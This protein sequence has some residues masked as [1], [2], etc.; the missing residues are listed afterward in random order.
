LM[1][2]SP[3]ALAGFASFL[4]GFGMGLL[5]FTCI[6]LIQDSVDWSLRG[7]ATASNIFARSLGSTLGATVLGAVLNAGIDRLASG[8]TAVRIH[9]VLDQPSGLALVAA[10]PSAQAVLAQALHLTFFGVLALALLAFA[11]SWFI[12]VPARRLGPAAVGT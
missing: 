12:P 7:S 1:P 8:D 2:Q 10:D 5:S 6:V 11:A 9:V 4:M 3:P